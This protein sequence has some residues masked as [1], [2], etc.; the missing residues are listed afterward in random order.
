MIEII[1]KQISY[2]FNVVFFIACFAIILLICLVIY[3]TTPQLYIFVIILC[4]T[5]I[6]ILMIYFAF[7]VIQPTR[8]IMNKN[9]W[10][11]VNPSKYTIGK[12]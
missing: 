4:I 11:I 9:Y 8:M 6:T 10:A 12:L 3:S 2:L 7:A 1:K 5:L